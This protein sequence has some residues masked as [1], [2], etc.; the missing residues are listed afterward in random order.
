ME[1]R[2]LALWGALVV[3]LS[4]QL[5]V[6]MVSSISDASTILTWG[7][8]EDNGPRLLTTA[9]VASVWHCEE[10]CSVPADSAEAGR[11][12]LAHGDSLDGLAHARS[13]KHAVMSR[14]S[15]SS[16]ITLSS[17]SSTVVYCLT[18]NG[19]L[20]VTL[21]AVASMAEGNKAARYFTVVNKES[22]NTCVV[23]TSSSQLIYTNLHTTAWQDTSPYDTVYG[24]QNAG[25]STAAFTDTTTMSPIYVHDAATLPVTTSHDAAFG[26]TTVIGSTQTAQ[27]KTVIASV[28]ANPT[29]VAGSITTSGQQCVYD[30]GR[31]FGTFRKSASVSS[32]ADVATAISAPK[33]SCYTD[34][35]VFNNNDG[36]QRY[37][38]KYVGND[39]NYDRGNYP[40][41]ITY[42]VNFGTHEIPNNYISTSLVVSSVYLSNHD[43]CATGLQGAGP[44]T[45][46]SAV[47]AITYQQNAVCLGSAG[48]SASTVVRTITPSP[49]SVVASFGLNPTPV[50]NSLPSISSY[51][52][53]T[54]YSVATTVKGNV[55]VSHGYSLRAP[56]TV[57]GV[58]TISDAGSATS[59]TSI[60]LQPGGSITLVTDGSA[61]YQ[62]AGSFGETTSL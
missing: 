23:Q 50:V 32:S 47:V 27:T 4:C 62:T 61:W 53:M 21:P 34:I 28:T 2:K 18:T 55:A 1:T 40:V 42:A 10:N 45:T 54:Q 30:L 44:T 46:A 3:C 22:S 33:T 9:Q 26:R 60:T 24:G 16:S 52:S 37:P 17:T 29:S 5:V 59:S 20:T 6:L 25:G 12:V 11:G 58:I 31:N 35:A 8:K 49:V 19:A 38:T 36:Y 41:R 7:R 56:T 13:I 39:N 57:T 14:S 48:R 15:T 51:A 43:Q